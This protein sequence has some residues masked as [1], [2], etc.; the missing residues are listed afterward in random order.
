MLAAQETEPGQ[1]TR[2]LVIMA[3]PAGEHVVSGK[4]DLWVTEGTLAQ[5]QLRLGQ[6]GGL[7]PILDSSWTFG[8][9][10]TVSLAG[11]IKNAGGFPWVLTL[12]CQSTALFYIGHVRV[13]LIK[14]GELSQVS[15]PQF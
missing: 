7:G 13:N 3:V 1:W 4:F 14:V 10:E 6:V 11:S 5:C 12:T 2:S 8:G 9:F 15:V